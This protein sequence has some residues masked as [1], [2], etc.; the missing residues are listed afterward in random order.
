[1]ALCL[2]AY[3]ALLA[4]LRES[5]S[6]SAFIQALQAA[7]P[8]SVGDGM[9]LLSIGPDAHLPHDIVLRRSTLLVP[10]YYPNLM[11]LM[12]TGPAWL[13][14][15]VPGTGK[16]WFVWYAMHVLLQQPRPPAIVWQTRGMQDACVLFKDGKALEGRLRDF[17]PEL[18][19]RE[20]W[21]VVGVI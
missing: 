1:M 14:T 19:E 4:G 2:P 16:S 6:L 11:H 7:K 15:G 12:T 20:T 13:L 8:K 5:P 3:S 10:D 18:G 17:W 21:Y 9:L